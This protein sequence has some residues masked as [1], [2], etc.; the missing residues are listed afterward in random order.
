MG[1]N[2]IAISISAGILALVAVIVWAS[3]NT[4]TPGIAASSKVLIEESWE[5][6]E[7]LAEISGIAFLEDNLLAGVQDEEGKIFIY[8]LETSQIEEEINF[9]G[10]GDYEGIAVAGSTA[11]VLRAD[12]TVFLVNNYRSTPEVEELQ[13]ILAVENDVEGL[14]YDAENNRLLLAVK[15]KDLQSED[16][17]GIYAID[18]KTKE[19]IEEPI[20]SLDFTHK[21]FKDVVDKDIQDTFKPSEINIHPTTGD[22]YILE[23]QKPKLLILDSEAQPKLLLELD[24]DEFPQPEGLSFDSAG[25]LYI[26]NEGEPGTIYRVSIK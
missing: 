1:I 19:F 14:C 7:S 25:D 22:Y 8:N 24:K 9:A 4:F 12:G 16:S 23:G 21:L 11:Y 10:K 3:G 15:E 5:L 6:P 20:F 17:K 13:T 18:L 26:S 2:K